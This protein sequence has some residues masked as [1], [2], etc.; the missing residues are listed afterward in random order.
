MVAKAKSNRKPR[1]K[2]IVQ[3]TVPFPKKNHPF[4]REPAVDGFVQALFDDAI[5]TKWLEPDGCD[6]EDLED[7]L[8]D[9]YDGWSIR[10]LCILLNASVDLHQKIVKEVDAKRFTAAFEYAKQLES[11][12]NAMQEYWS[13]DPV[14][15]VWIV[16]AFF[17]A[18][19]ANFKAAQRIMNPFRE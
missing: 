2:R 9:Q 5:R 19:H 15:D 17:K 12:R 11:V 14:E 3:R 16:D 4:M 18:I 7:C 13:G 8:L 1:Q 6:P 10:R